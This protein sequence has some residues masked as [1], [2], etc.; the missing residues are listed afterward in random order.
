MACG[1]PGPAGQFTAATALGAGRL[2]KWTVSTADVGCDTV[3]TPDEVRILLGP[4]L[5]VSVSSSLLLLAPT[6]E[7]DSKWTGRGGCKP[8]QTWEALPA[9][10]PKLGMLPVQANE[11]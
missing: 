11:G 10:T 8:L 9:I 6:L 4:I 7:Q 5:Q 3:P 2:P 1:T